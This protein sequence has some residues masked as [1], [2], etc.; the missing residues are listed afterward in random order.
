MVAYAPYF[1]ATAS[2]SSV[3]HA[4][5]PS[6]FSTAPICQVVTATVTEY[7]TARP[8]TNSHGHGGPY[9]N[10]YNDVP[11]PFEWPG[12]PSHGEAY[13]PPQP[14][15]PYEYG[16]PAKHDYEEPCW[17]TKGTDH[18]KSSLPN[19]E[20]C[21]NSQWGLIDTPH[22]PANGLPGSNP[23]G[24]Y[25]SE[26]TRLPST[27]SLHPTV[28]G[29][30]YGYANA[31][32]STTFG[33]TA[34][35]TLEPIASAASKPKADLLCPSMPDTGVTRTYDLHVAYQTIAPDGV[36][37]NGLTVNGQFPG[38]LIEANWGDWILWRVTNDLTD[39]GTT[40][41]AHGL[42]Q[43]ESTWYDGVPA[44]SQCP[45]TP[46]GGYY[47]MLFRADRYGTSWYHSHYSAQYS[48]GAHGPMVIH[49]PKHEDYDIDIGPIILEDWF[50][51]DYYTLVEG[52]MNGQFPPSN[53]NLING[54][55]NYPCANTTL[56][57]T[58]NA[59]ISKFKFQSGKKHLLRLI[60]TGA[61]GNQKFSIDGHKL[62]VIAVDY[63][64]VEPYT[65]NVV[66]LA[67][68]QRTDVIVEAIGKPSDTFWMR[69][70]LA[71]GFRC[72][73]TDGIS[74]NALAA[75]Y[76]ENASTDAIPKSTSDVTKEQLEQCKNDPITQ[77]I[78]LCKVPLEEPDHVERVDFDFRSNGT[79]FIWYLNNST[80]HGNY[81]KPTLLKAKRNES[82]FNPEWNVYQFPGAKHVRIHMVNHGLIGGH[83]M[84]LH[85]H[86]YHI[87]AEGFGE[88][89]G[90]VTN[91]ENTL[92][93]DVH[94]M[95]N[96]RNTTGTVEPS[97]LVLQFAQD[98][99]GAWPLH[100]H[101][102]WHVSGGLFMQIL[103]RPEDIQKQTFG[104][105]QFQLCNDWDA[106][107]SEVVLNQID[108]GL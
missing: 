5:T 9:Y 41:H 51:A 87:L 104:D 30:P 74:P 89:D 70:Q 59:G 18:L 56:P 91:P 46:N 21:G 99:P 65:T 82:D 37:R 49:G 90:V 4:V 71:Q 84:H 94:Q 103:E 20:Q 12:K 105:E 101:L 32:G 14:S 63:I 92:R 98:N 26:P 57:C 48:G 11:L 19:V 53:N 79:N 73:L 61:E 62:K 97:Y 6:E 42:L 3:L 38:P 76:Y 85:G 68:G 69:S 31:T 24:A 66:T 43:T 44:V 13:A 36:T 58:P 93:R 10:P 25:T 27:H 50:H 35:G 16:G 95:Q 33:P 72:T 64:P 88:W 86:D 47:E 40:L 8:T 60:N 77:G 75:V 80:Y 83:P 23:D 107:T 29:Y 39:E 34:A 55:M 7:A 15:T 100:C 1:A 17:V 102:A 108:S 45:I 54:R 96:A 28:S 106:Y 67:V 2:L 22:L 78:P 52:T 81:N